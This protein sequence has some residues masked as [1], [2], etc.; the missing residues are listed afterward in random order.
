MSIKFDK[1]MNY[2]FIRGIN[3]VHRI[4]EIVIGNVARL[5]KTYEIVDSRTKLMRRPILHACFRYC[6]A[7]MRQMGLRHV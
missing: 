3:E 4:N 1:F 6:C 2:R 5:N 7:V